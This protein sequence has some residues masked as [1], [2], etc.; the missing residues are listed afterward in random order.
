[1][2]LLDVF[3][4]PGS[5]G[6][7]CARHLLAPEMRRSRLGPEFEVQQILALGFRV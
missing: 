4:T 5:K 7:D 6:K 3:G 2:S 1:M